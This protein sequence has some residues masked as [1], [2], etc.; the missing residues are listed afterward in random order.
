M[1]DHRWPKE[2]GAN[3]YTLKKV[4]YDHSKEYL[5]TSTRSSITSEN[6]GVETIKTE[7]VE[8]AY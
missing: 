7:L 5:S 8:E 1:D 2:L 3:S 6:Y 4:N